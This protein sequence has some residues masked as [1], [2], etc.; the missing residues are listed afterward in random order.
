M[1]YLRTSPFFAVFALAYFPAAG[2]L[3]QPLGWAYGLTLWLAAGTVFTLLLH[4]SPELLKERL[5]P[6][7]DRDQNSRR[8][9]IPGMVLHWVLAGLDARYGWSHVP[10]PLSIVGDVLV[11]AALALTGWTLLSNPYASTAV[12]IQSER[13]HEVITGGP[14]KFVRHPMYLGVLLLGLGSGPALGSWWAQLF[15]VPLLVVFVLRTLKE[16]RMLH[17]ELKGYPEYA[18]RVRWRVVP[19][20]F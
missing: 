10:L 14:Y 4:K 18:A 17:G 9:A 16:D 3:T 19:G 5:K 1:M 15:V 20:V 11:A 2:S 13:G 7:S 6:P 12:R 8:I